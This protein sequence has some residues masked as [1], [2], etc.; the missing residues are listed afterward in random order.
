VGGQEGSGK[1]PLGRHR[2]HARIGA[3]EPVGMVFRS[4]KP[5]G[6]IWRGEDRDEDLI[7]TRVLTLEGLEDGV[8]RGPGCDSLARFIYLHGTNQEALL[9][10]PVSHGCVRLSNADVLA[11]FDRVE[12]GD[13][14]VIG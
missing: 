8:N 4:R 2:V 5:T 10:T 13:L 11:L 12:E 9:G 3:G 14:V 6:E 1:T 7:L